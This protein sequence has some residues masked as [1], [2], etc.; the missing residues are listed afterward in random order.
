MNQLKIRVLSSYFH[1]VSYTFSLKL[2][3]IRTFSMVTYKDR[4]LKIWTNMWYNEKYARQ[5]LYTQSEHTLKSSKI[6]VPKNY[7]VY[8]IM[9]KNV[10]QPDKTQTTASLQYDLH[11]GQLN[12]EYRHIYIMITLYLIINSVRSRKMFYSNIYKNWET[13]LRLVCHYD[14]LGQGYVFSRPWAKEH[15]FVSTQHLYITC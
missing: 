1:T 8:K 3:Y 10:T 15:Y 2:I 5:N 12:Q 6:F 7:A 9:W 11:A 14:L 13:V 4:C